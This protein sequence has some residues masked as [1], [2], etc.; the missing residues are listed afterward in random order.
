MVS[1]L[2]NKVFIST[3]PKD[4]SLELD[5]LLKQHEAKHFELP[6]IE[7][8]ENADQD[9]IEHKLNDIQDYSHVAFTSANGFLF[10]HD[11][12]EQLKDGKNILSTLKIA[13]IGYKT[14]QLIKSYGY[15]IDF[16]GKTKTGYEFAKKL[17]A[18]LLNKN[19]K[20]LW[21]TGNLSPDVILNEIAN[22]ATWVRLNIYQNT[23]PTN[24]SNE[25][26]E[27][28][29]ND[30]YDM[31]VCTSPS[32]FNNLMKN[33]QQQ[34]LKIACIGQITANAALTQGI[35]PLCIAE[36]PN[37]LGIFNAILAYYKNI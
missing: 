30:K 19:A 9:L 27:L 24:I 11:K 10:F 23:M 36:E 20:V 1:V 6:M 22:T 18:Y 5:Q 2:K 35:T 4:K 13:S 12:I 33:T 34:N 25:L 16:D 15:H 37:A 28:I 31:I 21:P 14:S 32:A 26:I 3:R 8:N 29:K 7:L 17:K